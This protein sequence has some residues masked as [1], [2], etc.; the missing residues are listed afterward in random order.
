MKWVAGNAISTFQLM[1]S[2]RSKFSK[3]A[4]PDAIKPIKELAIETALLVTAIFQLF[5]HN[6]GTMNN[7]VLESVSFAKYLGVDISANL[8][9]N[10]HIKRISS[11]ANKSLGFSE[12][13][14]LCNHPVVRKSSYKTIVRP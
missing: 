3:A 6:Q 4:D 7:Q 12:R 10:S 11:N 9:F 14:V 5:T 13:N 8:S 2:Q 1:G